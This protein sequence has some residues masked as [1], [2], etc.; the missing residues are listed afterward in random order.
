METM[1]FYRRAA[2]ERTSAEIARHT[3]GLVRLPLGAANFAPRVC[4]VCRGAG[5]DASG[6][7]CHLC[8]GAGTTRCFVPDD[9]TLTVLV[10]GPLGLGRQR[11]VAVALADGRPAFVHVVSD[12]VRDVRVYTI[13][14][15]ARR[16]RGRLRLAA[17]R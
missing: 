15:A 16:S 11:L 10:H 1:V 9:P 5:R 12:G 3:R 13:S 14:A 17:A 6:R 8:G 4:C 7:V 2:S